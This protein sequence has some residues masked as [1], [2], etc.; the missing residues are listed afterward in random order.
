MPTRDVNFLLSLPTQIFN[1]TL[2]HSAACVD[3]GVRQIRRSWNIVGF[4]C[5]CKSNQHATFW[6]EQWSSAG[7]NSPQHVGARS[8]KTDLV[9]D[10]AALP[11]RVSNRPSENSLG[12]FNNLARNLST[13]CRTDRVKFPQ[14]VCR[15]ITKQNH[16]ILAQF[17]E[18]PINTPNGESPPTHSTRMENYRQPQRPSVDEM[19][20]HQPG[21]TAMHQRVAVFAPSPATFAQMSTN[22]A[23]KSVGADRCISPPTSWR[24]LID[25]PDR[26]FPSIRAFKC[27]VRFRRAIACSRILQ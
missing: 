27:F 19:D 18:G 10:P 26:N 2:N 25:T 16:W 23:P 6:D 12:L 24:S 11:F 21:W 3:K 17:W 15:Q 1:K 5:E 13:N 20:C 9:N 7:F 22:S 14:F 4:I 8:K